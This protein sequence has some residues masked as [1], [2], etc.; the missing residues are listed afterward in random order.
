MKN[1]TLF[2][3]KEKFCDWYFDDDTCNEFFDRYSV[4]SELIE[5]GTFEIKLDHILENVGYLPENVIADKQKPILD[6][7]GE[8]DMNAYEQIIFANN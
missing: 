4:L 7:Y 2:I 5:K 8:I 6:K 3:D 1:K